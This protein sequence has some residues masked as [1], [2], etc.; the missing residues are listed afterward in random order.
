MKCVYKY[1]FIS[2]TWTFLF[3]SFFFIACSVHHNDIEIDMP[4]DLVMFPPIDT[5]IVSH[6]EWTRSHYQNRI[7][8]FKENPIEPNSIVMLG[9]SLTEQ[10]GNWAIRLGK[11]SVSNRGIAGDNTDGLKARLGEIICAKPTAVFVMIGTN[12]LWT[13]FSENEVASKINDIGVY[14]AD[15]LHDS[16]IFIQTIMPVGEGNDRN[17]RLQNINSYLRGFEQMPYILIDTWELMSDADGYLANTLTT[18]GVH[19][20]ENGYKKWAAILK[21]KLE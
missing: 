1:Y 12:D 13:N 11:D 10:G 8:E 7:A 9:N 17:I 19:L 18:D 21:A 20:T 4:C 2:L 5:V 3:I 15:N 6:T 16:K 14:L